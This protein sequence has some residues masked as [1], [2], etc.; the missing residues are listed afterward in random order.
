MPKKNLHIWMPGYL[1]WKLRAG[2]QVRSIK[3]IVFCF[4]DHYEPQWGNDVDIEQ[5]R[6]RVDRWYNDYQEVASKHKDSDGCHPKHTFFYPEEEYRE[7]H[8]D[9]LAKL[10]R[11]GFGEIEIHIHHHD[12]TSD[13]LRKTL[14]GYA[15]RL[16]EHHG[17]LSRFPETGE[18]A[19]GFIHGN[20]ALDNCRPDGKRCGVNDELIVLRETGCYADFTY[21]AAPSPCQT[22]KVNAVYYATDDPY[23]PKSHDTGK[24]VAVG[25][26]PRG[27]LMIIQ[28]P[29]GLNWK[30][31]KKRLFPTIENADIR[32]EFPPSPNRVDLWVDTNIHVK[33]RP[34]WIFVK[35]HTHGAQERLLDV[36][37]GKSFDEMCSYLENRYNDGHN[38]ALHYV[39]AR[40]LYNVIKAAEDGKTGN[41]GQYRDY[42]LPPPKYEKVAG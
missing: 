24:D 32:A 5:E 40:E 39:S 13:N 10:C 37:L 42:I 35:I 19:Y 22:R 23:R 33:G 18:V 34:D 28:G 16:H 31:R 1:A 6:Y 25:E 15:R 30:D 41:P 38:F 11:G 7:E 14:A 4:V 8:L 26:A 29:L 36:L 21:P 17:V 9:K 3:H 27:D 20:W 12:D 2:R